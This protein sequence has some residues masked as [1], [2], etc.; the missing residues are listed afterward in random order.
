M[1]DPDLRELLVRDPVVHRINEIMTTLFD[2]AGVVLLA[3]SAWVGVGDRLWPGAQWTAAAFFVLT[4]SALAQR[5]DRVPK[6]KRPLRPYVP[7]PS[8]PGTVHIAGGQ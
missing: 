8:D 1:T 4:G 5:R 3:I 7:G 6:L 2:M